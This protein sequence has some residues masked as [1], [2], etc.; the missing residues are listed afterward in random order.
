MKGTAAMEQRTTKRNTRIFTGFL[1]LAGFLHFFDPTQ[2]LALN[3]FIFCA[4]FAIYAGLV[5]FWIR[6][7]RIRL[8][9]TRIRGYMTAAGLLMLSFLAMR[10]FKYRIVGDYEG[11]VAVSRYTAYAYWAPQM[12]VPSLFL[13]ACVRIRNGNPDRGRRNEALLLIPGAA[14]A[15]TALTNDLHQWVYRPRIDLSQ[16]NVTGG[17]YSYGA[18]FYC[19]Y[20]WMI[21]AWVTGLVLLLRETGRRPGKETLRLAGVILLWLVM[22]LLNKLVFDNL[23]VHQPYTSP[24]IHI[25]SMLGVFEVCIRNRLIPGNGNHAGFF[26][27][28]GL[29]VLITD[30]ELSPAYRTDRETAASEADL[31]ASL[32][33][34]VYPR[35]D[36]RLSGMA[37]RGGYAFW[38]EDESELRRENRRLES[39]NEILSQEN[40]LIR[41]ENELK[42]KK[43]RLDAQNLVYERITAALY[44]RQ[45]RIESLLDGT[46]PGTEDFRRALGECCV[47]NA[48][49]K[50]KSNLLLLNGKELPERN[51][52][53]FLALQESARFLKCCGVEAAAVGE[54]TADFPLSD[55]HDLYDAFETVIE[56][57]LPS[58]RRMTVSLTDGGIRLA[59]DADGAPELPETALPVE[60]KISEGT[61]FLT[62]R[63]K[64]GKAA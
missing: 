24:E 43:A 53:L 4:V 63:R 23:R 61:V 56:A 46:E 30:R 26:G 25:F 10:V 31:R 18:A 49:C 22:L 11:D 17:T 1:L 54:E 42:E 35:K 27:Q 51:R 8:L 41:A 57:W 13:M 16:F 47:L 60:K 28:L 12:L 33:A 39:A 55:I 40:E 20:A 21:I 9:P 59:V 7:V 52:E 34:P 44:P 62:I 2:N 19:L 29:P 38:E 32:E 64:G 15:V 50:R 3:T 6:S 14:L 37:I 45:K 48:W 36:L 58:L 5:L